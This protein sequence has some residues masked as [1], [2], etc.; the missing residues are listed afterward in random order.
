MLQSG[1]Y[2]DLTIK[3]GL[4]TWTVHKAIVCAQCDFFDSA[5]RKGLEARSAPRPGSFTDIFP[6]PCCEGTLHGIMYFY[7]ENIISRA[8]LM[9]VQITFDVNVNSRSSTNASMKAN[10]Q[11]P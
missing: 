1:K 11:L 2:S 6:L 3:S 8:S 10:L 4:Q 5:C 9:Y 7:H